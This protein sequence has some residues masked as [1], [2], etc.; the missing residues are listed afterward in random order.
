[1]I[2]AVLSEGDDTL[3]SFR[4]AVPPVDPVELLKS[5]YATTFAN[6][7]MLGGMQGL[8][9]HD[10]ADQAHMMTNA[11]IP[12]SPQLQAES[13]LGLAHGLYQHNPGMGQAM[14]NWFTVDMPVIVGTPPASD[15]KI[16]MT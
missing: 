14:I 5:Q 10:A 11:Q 4:K 2:H 8:S 3:R 9:F 12:I 7:V 15:W 13:I 6:M 16:V 1:M